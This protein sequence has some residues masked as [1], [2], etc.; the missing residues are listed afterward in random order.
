[1]DYKRDEVLNDTI[2][3]PELEQILQN[4]FRSGEPRRYA[5][6]AIMD[7]AIV[8]RKRRRITMQEYKTAIERYLAKIA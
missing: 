5:R 7:E 3:H 4:M 6:V 2:A 8:M 1:M